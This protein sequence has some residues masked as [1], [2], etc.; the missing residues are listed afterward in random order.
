[1]KKIE[2]AMVL[3]AGLGRRMRPLTDTLPKPLIEVAGR[4]L[5]DRVFD[6]LIEAGVTRIVVNLHH[7]RAT[8]EAHLAKRH[9]A[10]FVLSPESDRLETGGGVLNALPLLGAAPFYCVN[11]DVLWF[12]GATPALT[13]LADA[14]FA[15]RP[16]TLLL[17]NSAARARGY[18]GRGDYFMDGAGKARRRLGNQIAPFVYAGVQI[19]APENFRDQT[20]GRFSL[21]RIYDAAQDAGGLYGVAH[22]GLWF[23]VGTPESVAETEFELGWRRAR[24]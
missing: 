20:P 6:R 17:M 14:W 10:T 23:H 13:R 21:N 15:Q 5:I 22:D 1:M 12:D 4:S 7:H 19:L 9:D 16:Q 11:A 8:L 3:A 24:P 18:E 2:T